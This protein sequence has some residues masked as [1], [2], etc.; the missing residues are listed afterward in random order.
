MLV[1]MLF[2]YGR[3]LGSLKTSGN[4]FPPAS[5]APDPLQPSA[6][7][8]VTFSGESTPPRPA[9]QQGGGVRGGPVSMPVVATREF[10]AAGRHKANVPAGA[11]VCASG[12]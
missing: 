10:S 12:L 3:T 1:T 4:S 2:Y 5:V 7:R 11:C 6:S 9:A 8:C